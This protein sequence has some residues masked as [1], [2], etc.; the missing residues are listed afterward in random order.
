[1]VYHRV[2]GILLESASMLSLL[3]SYV[4]GVH[5]HTNNRTYLCPPTKEMSWEKDVTLFL[6]TK[7]AFNKVTDYSSACSVTGK[8]VQK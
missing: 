3:I 6:Y 4:I 1:M 5:M 7:K 2:T 8:P